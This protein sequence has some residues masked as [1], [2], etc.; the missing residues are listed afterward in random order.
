MLL[1]QPSGPV[2][3]HHHGHVGLLAAFRDLHQKPLP[4]EVS[5]ELLGAR[6]NGAGRPALIPAASSSIEADSS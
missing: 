1:H 6:N 2:L 5:T 4:S 3:H